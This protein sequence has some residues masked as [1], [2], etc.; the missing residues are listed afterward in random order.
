MP[1]ISEFFG[2]DIHLCTPRIVEC[3]EENKT[4]VK[5]RFSAQSKTYLQ[6]FDIW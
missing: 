5:Y 6:Y 3:T 4:A 1:K 2:I